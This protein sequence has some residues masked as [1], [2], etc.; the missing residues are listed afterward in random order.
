AASLPCP[1]EKPCSE[2]STVSVSQGAKKNLKKRRKRRWLG[3]LLIDDDPDELIGSFDANV[4]DNMHEDFSTMVAPPIHG[5]YTSLLFGL[6]Q[7]A[8]AA[9][10]L[11]FD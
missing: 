6:D 11:Y 10:K 7:D 1:I 8:M 5:E 3:E 4:D 2:W 9:R